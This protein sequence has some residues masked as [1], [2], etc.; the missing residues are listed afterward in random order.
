M[1]EVQNIIYKTYNHVMAF[2]GFDIKILLSQKK[3]TEER[4]VWG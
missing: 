1:L 4:P 2:R 3:K